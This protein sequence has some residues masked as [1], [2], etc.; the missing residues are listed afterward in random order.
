MWNWKCCFSRECPNIWRKK[1]HGVF[2]FTKD[3]SCAKV[4]PYEAVFLSKKCCF[5]SGDHRIS[6]FNYCSIKWYHWTSLY[7]NYS[8][9]C[10]Y[11]GNYCILAFNYCSTKYHWILVYCNYSNVAHPMLTCT[12]NVSLHT[13]DSVPNP[14]KCNFAQTLLYCTPKVNLHT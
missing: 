1:T 11:S 13:Q 12:P 6:A 2:T 5:Y 9:A 10:V 8:N 14:R 4:L 7:C 3:Y